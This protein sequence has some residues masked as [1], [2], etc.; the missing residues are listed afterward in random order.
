[1]TPVICSPPGKPASTAL[2]DLVGGRVTARRAAGDVV[3]YK[4]VGS[5]LQDVVL[6]GALLDRARATGVG[7][8]LPVSI[9]PV[10][11]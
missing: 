6:A 3:V 4:S 2:S 8:E 9:A 5:A 10:A 1:M 7:T 11:K